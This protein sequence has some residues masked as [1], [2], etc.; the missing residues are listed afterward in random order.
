LEN[1]ALRQSAREAVQPIKNWLINKYEGVETH[2]TFYNCSKIRAIAP[3][4]KPVEFI[5]HEYTFGALVVFPERQPILQ[6]CFEL[7]SML[8]MI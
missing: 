7:Q 4:H 3:N 5:F 6:T 8:K 2:C 1:L